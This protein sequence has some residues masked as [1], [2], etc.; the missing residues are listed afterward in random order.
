MR[1]QTTIIAAGI[2][3]AGFLI[4]PASAS[5]MSNCNKLIKAWDECRA[6]GG[7]CKAEQKTLETECKCHKQ[8][9]DEW[10]LVIAA[11]GK[12]GVCAPR[13]WPPTPPPDPSPPRHDDSDH[14]PDDKSAN[15]K[16]ERGRRQ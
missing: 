15:K 12:D 3:A 16:E 6:D 8:K 13:P 9:G 7:D 5:Y 14:Q 2:I 4:T 11:V 10:K 1:R